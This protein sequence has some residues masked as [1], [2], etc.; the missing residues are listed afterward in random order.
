ML[1]ARAM[2]LQLLD[3]IAADEIEEHR[4]V[5]GV[6]DDEH[7]LIVKEARIDGVADRAHARDGVIEFEMAVAVPGERCDAVALSDA[8]PG[9][10]MSELFRPGM[11]LADGITVRWPVAAAADDFGRAVMAIGML[12]ER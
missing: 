4:L 3:H 2:R 1:H 10:R 7:N 11:R 8:E 9:Q 5:L 6:I 12:N